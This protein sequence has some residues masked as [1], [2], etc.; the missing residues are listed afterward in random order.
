MQNVYA[1]QAT[2]A[3][4]G[5]HSRADRAA[6]FDALTFA[7][8]AWATQMKLESPDGG[9]RP[10]VSD[11]VLDAER[12][13][14]TLRA[15][16]PL[17]PNEPWRYV[18][19]VGLAVTPVGLQG[20]VILRVVRAR[21]DGST[22]RYEPFRPGVVD[23]LLGLAHASALG[24]E[25]IP[26]A[27]VRYDVTAVPRL[28]DELLLNPTRQLPLV[29]L[30]PAESGR[31]LVDA[32][33]VMEELLGLAHVAELA[34]RDATFALTKRVG[35][36]WS[37]FNG[38]ARIYWPKLT[39][40]DSY[41]QHPIFFPGDYPPGDDTDDRLPLDIHRKLIAAALRRT[42]EAPLVTQLR[43]LAD[44]QAQGQ[45]EARLAELARGVAEGR[46]FMAALEQAWSE[47]RALA[48]EAQLLRAE[49][50]ELQDSHAAMEEQW[51][52]VSADIA[53]AQAAAQAERRAA[54]RYRLK[55]LAGMKRVREAVSLAQEEFAETL[56]FLPSAVKSAD[57][58]PYLDPARVFAL[59]A[60]LDGVARA[61]KAR[62]GLGEDLHAVLLRAGFEYKPHISMTSE[63]KHGD[64]YHFG[65][66]G[67]RK[68]F[69]SHVT[70]G[71][72]HNPQECLSVHWRREGPE[73]FVIAWCGK[74]RTNTRS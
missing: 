69:E 53:Q 50:A 13:V 3:P 58:S 66:Q 43:A 28:V 36:F 37:C 72:S 55:Y 1:F 5:G 59:F 57:D 31:P 54:E 71:G 42:V 21:D 17:D 4:H 29:V 44:R 34:S 27:A 18:C 74:H 68:L 45:T 56:V 32:G 26:P 70:L 60:A 8:R 14:L 39:L 9:G 22:V 19:E 64:E 25:P 46:E 67:E 65:Y 62:G 35:K 63:G 38:A 49:L 6:C 40:D 10:T 16:Y 12:R 33:V 20:H 30:A 61:V 23:R 11:G 51:A 7:T 2:F 73:R 52:T 47:N 24:G 48:D 41:R 15:A